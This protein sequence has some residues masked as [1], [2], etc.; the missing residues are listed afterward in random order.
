[1]FIVEDL[2][3]DIRFLD[4]PLCTQT[5]NV[6]F[7]AGVPLMSPEGLPIGTLCAI[8]SVPRKLTPVQLSTLK[9]LS[10]QMMAQLELRRLLKNKK[11]KLLN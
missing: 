7:Y 5:P 2:S 10:K 1:M 3:K 6:R 8:D 11:N 4:N 9:T